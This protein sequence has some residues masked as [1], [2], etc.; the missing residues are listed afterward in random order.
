ME[1]RILAVFG[2]QPNKR[3]LCISGKFHVEESYSVFVSETKEDGLYEFLFTEGFRSL[4]PCRG[5]CVQTTLTISEAQMRQLR[6][7]L[8]EIDLKET[9]RQQMDELRKKA[10]GAQQMY[11]KVMMEIASLQTSCAPHPNRVESIASHDE[12]V[13][14]WRCHDCDDVGSYR[15]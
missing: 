3:H 5:T 2:G 9:I 13:M 15:C 6:L 10:G 8:P 14:L 7:I 4:G 12:R 11:A 1:G